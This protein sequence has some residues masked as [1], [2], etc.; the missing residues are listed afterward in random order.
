MRRNVCGKLES[1]APNVRSHYL[2][3][4]AP[5]SFAKPHTVASAAGNVNQKQAKGAGRTEA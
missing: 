3:L 1:A 2:Q 5:A 4:T